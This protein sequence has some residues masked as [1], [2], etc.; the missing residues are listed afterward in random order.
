MKKICVNVLIHVAGSECV[1]VSV[2]GEDGSVD[3]GQV[4][5]RNVSL[6]G[7]V[8]YC[9]AKVGVQKLGSFYN[10][11]PFFGCG[12]FLFQLEHAD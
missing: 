12:G 3:Y 9:C 2:F 5:R 6:S 1:N 10:E 11:R 4:E 8:G 7:K